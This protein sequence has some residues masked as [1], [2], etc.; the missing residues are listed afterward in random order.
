MKTI[1]LTFLLLSNL[2]AYEKGDLISEEMTSQL[3]LSDNKLY[4]ID[5]FASWCGSCKKELPLIAQVDKK[6][7]HKKVEIIGIDV[8]KNRENGLLFQQELRNKHGLDFR[9]VNDPEGKIISTFN[10]VGM[11][12]LYYI[13]DRK[14]IGIITGAVD[15]IDKE[16]L[17]IIAGQK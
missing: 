5:F 10:P 3:G 1:L 12:T 13:K 6:I 4:I 15:H 11:P 17:S 8:D 16:I 14:I 7:D 2:L 9:V